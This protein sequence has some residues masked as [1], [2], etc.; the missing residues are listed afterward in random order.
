STE[1]PAPELISR[2]EEL[3]GIVAS[4][5]GEKNLVYE[6]ARS[7]NQEL[8][9]KATAAAE[10]CQQMKSD[11]QA[12]ES[13][14]EAL[15]MIA[16]ESSSGATGDTQ[17]KLLRQMETLQSQYTIA[18]ENWQRIEASFVSRLAS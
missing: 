9:A 4:L 15:R 1:A 3:E 7:E 12:T 2:I 13:R 14:L 17:A 11:L 10:Q 6:S 8:R 16:E 5:E 18:S